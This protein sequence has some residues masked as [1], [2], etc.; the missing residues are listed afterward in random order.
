MVYLVFFKSVALLFL[1]QEI[2]DCPVMFDA[3]GASR[4]DVKQGVL[5]KSNL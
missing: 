2:S 1:L 4:L 3:E 5:G